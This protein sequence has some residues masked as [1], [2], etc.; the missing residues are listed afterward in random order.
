MKYIKLIRR[1]VPVYGRERCSTDN[2][3]LKNVKEPGKIREVP[4]I[5]LRVQLLFL[6]DHQDHAGMEVEAEL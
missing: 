4:L 6:K 2:S 1:S 3:F 5:I